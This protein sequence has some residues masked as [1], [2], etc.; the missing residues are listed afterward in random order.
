MVKYGY[1]SN[2]HR[3]SKELPPSIVACPYCL[4]L[5]TPRSRFSWGTY[6]VLLIIFWAF[7]IP[8]TVYWL[9][10]RG[11]YKCPNCNLSP[12]LDK[13]GN[14]V[15]MPKNWGPEV[16]NG[17]SAAD[18]KKL[19]HQLKTV[20]A[21][22]SGIA[23]VRSELQERATSAKAMNTSKPVGFTMAQKANLVWAV[24]WLIVWLVFLGPI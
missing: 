16:L 14:V 2:C 7:F 5:V 20:H 1:Y 19:E 21:D 24:F 17:L 3:T 9:Y 8:S 4:Q 15:S 12:L 11:K 23:R 22:P 6:L 18:L 13:L 10:R